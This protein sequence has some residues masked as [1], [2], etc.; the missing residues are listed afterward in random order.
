MENETKKIRF[1]DTMAGPT[2][3]LLIICLVVSGA[4]AF[5]YQLTAPQIE[6][7]N[8]ENADAAR[9][10]VLPD[11]DSFTA[12]EDDMPE[13]VTEYYVA[14]NG[15]G[16]VVTAQNKSFGGTITVMVGF[17]PEGTITGVKVT[18]HADTPGLGTKAQDAAYLEKQYVGKTSTDNAEG[19]IKKDSQIDEVTG[20]TVSSN[21][22]YGAVNYAI[23]AFGEMGGLQ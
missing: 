19:G 12:V 15:S 13:G 9:L 10:V 18:A 6:K 11:A 16:A 4:L 5:T 8:K 2:V 7:I 1:K 14:N 17:D 20:A 21:G 22:V 3:V 23:A